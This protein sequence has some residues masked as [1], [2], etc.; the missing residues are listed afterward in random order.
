MYLT[1]ILPPKKKKK[2]TKTL[3][4]TLHWKPKKK[5]LKEEDKANAY[6]IAEYGLVSAIHLEKRKSSR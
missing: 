2:T 6:L 4:K 3:Q 5:T 1:Y